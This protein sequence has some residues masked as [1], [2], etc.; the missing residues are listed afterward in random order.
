MQHHI[1]S[2]LTPRGQKSVVYVDIDETIS[3]YDSDRSYDLAV[4]VRENIAKI[5]NLYDLGWHVIYW[6]ARGSV[7]GTDYHAFTWKQ[8]ESWGCQFHDLITGKAKG[9]FDMLIDDKSCKIE[10]LSEDGEVID[11]RAIARKMYYNC[12]EALTEKEKKAVGVL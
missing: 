8:L 7:S 11:F 6:T 1:S 5:N 2:R 9:H 10:D 12:R 4:P 3:R